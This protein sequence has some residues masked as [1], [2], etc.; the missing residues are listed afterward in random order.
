M[1]S[2]EAKVS[3]ENFG[4]LPVFIAQGLRLYGAKQTTPVSEPES[5]YTVLWGTLQT[6]IEKLRYTQKSDY[7]Q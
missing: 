6:P 3:G 4:L 7:T 5:P 2:L 1:K